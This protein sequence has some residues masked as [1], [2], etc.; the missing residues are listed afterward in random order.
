MKN[1][2][3]S[4]FILSLLACDPIT[5]RTNDKFEIKRGTNVGHWLSQSKR[6]GLER[7]QY[8]TK[9]DIETVAEMGLDHIRLPIDE[10]QMWDEEGNRNEDA[11]KLMLSCIDWC[12][13]S[14]L[15]VIVD[16]HILRSH[17]FI[18]EV[19]P[20]WTDP[21][22]QDKFYDLWRDL[23]KALKVY[24]NN[25]LAYE[26]MNE[27]VADDPE[28]WNDLLKNCY[29]AIRELEPE[30]TIVIGSNMWQSVNTFD[31]LK[32]PANDPNILLSFHY[33]HPMI[34][35]HYN[36]GWTIF[37]NYSGPVHYPGIL[38]TQEEFNDLPDEEKTSFVEAC[39]NQE[40]NKEII[41]KMWEQPIKKA[42]ELG[43]PLYCGEFGVYFDAPESDMLR[44][45]EDMIQLFEEHDI[46]YA[47]WNFKSSSFGLLDNEG[48][49][50][51]ALINVMSPK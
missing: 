30:R 22:E 31:D 4:I 29:D 26:L 44:W 48:N 1:L 41:F 19:K 39:I 6:R 11:F 45:Y 32:V 42:K 18:A 12:M 43:L 46:G 23:S 51:E 9:S 7:E 35:T 36:A 17:H 14:S 47:N 15:K 21:S 49:R 13:E 20:L 40:F 27:A 3:I 16:L 5:S 10:E 37:K 25:M 8:I 28:M 2:L 38:I 50:Y 24:P 33:Y 34:L